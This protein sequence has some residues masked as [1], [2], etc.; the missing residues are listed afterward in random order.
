MITLALQGDWN[1]AKGRIKQ[2][3][4]KLTDDR[5]R[6]SEGRQEEILGRIQKRTD[7]RCDDIEGALKE[8]C[9]RGLTKPVA[10]TTQPGTA[11]EVWRKSACHVAPDHDPFRASVKDDRSHSPTRPL[12]L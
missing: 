10:G 5:L 11:H 12:F 4:A 7:E 6:L 8:S 1:I 2:G 9:A 3:W